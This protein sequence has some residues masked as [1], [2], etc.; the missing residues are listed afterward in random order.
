MT[1]DDIEAIRQELKGIKSV[2]NIILGSD[3]TA[4]STSGNQVI[5]NGLLTTIN[6][7]L[8]VIET[9]TAAGNNPN[10]QATML[11]SSPV[12]IASDQSTLPI[13][14]ATLPLPTGAATSAGITTLNTNI[15]NMRSLNLTDILVALN[16]IGTKTATYISETVWHVIGLPNALSLNPSLDYYIRKAT[17]TNGYATSTVE[18]YTINGTSVDVSG[19]INTLIQ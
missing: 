5:T 7:S 11:N 2:L 13:S 16:D 8:D 12:V 1:R 4:S 15:T 17:Y 18:W 14:A 9:N 19:F 6:A 3:S 10:G